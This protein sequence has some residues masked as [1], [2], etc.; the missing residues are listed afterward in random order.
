M[1]EEEWAHLWDT[2]VETPVWTEL[3]PESQAAFKR[4]WYERALPLFAMIIGA[5]GDYDRQLKAERN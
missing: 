1:T 4:A 5:V 3:L 2:F